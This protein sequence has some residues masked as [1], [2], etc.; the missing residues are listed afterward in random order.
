[1]AWM[2]VA[3]PVIGSVASSVVGGI[4]GKDDLKRANALDERAVALGDDLT[5]VGDRM[6]DWA[7]ERWQFY[8][9]MG[10]PADIALIN[11]A[12]EYARKGPEA[13]VQRVRADVNTAYD[14][15]QGITE[16]RMQ[17][18]GVDPSSG[19]YVGSQRGVEMNR[20]ASEVG[21]ANRARREEEREAFRRLGGA[22]DVGNRALSQ[23]SRF[24]SGAQDAYGTASNIYTGGANRAADSYSGTQEFVG[25]VSSRIPWEDALRGVVDMARGS[26]SG[27]VEG[28]WAGNGY[29]PGDHVPQPI[30]WPSVPASGMADGG[31][32][33]ALPVPVAGRKVVG[34]GGPR[35]DAIPAV[36]DGQQ[37]AALSSGEFVIPE[38]V[39]RWKGEEF[40]HK[41][42]NA[43]GQEG[44]K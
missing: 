8:Q 38:H 11:Q 44:Q 3:A 41:L 32:V 28:E 15:A 14:R 34:P 43:A 19:R 31:P 42:I 9:D 24:G 10:Q 4:L 20:A 13:A 18:Y 40:F 39:V 21:S 5:G 37:P 33:S 36:V 22:S 25:D 17:R 30:R 23:A 35:E 12:M 26:D 6:W 7:N 29:D 27:I 1:M 16:R 2:A